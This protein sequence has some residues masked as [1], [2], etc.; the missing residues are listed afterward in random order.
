MYPDDLCALLGSFQV[1]DILI[2]IPVF[3]VCWQVGAATFGGIIYR[4][5]RGFE[6]KN[7]GMYIS[8]VLVM[9]AGI[10][11]ATR[12]M[13]IV[14]AAAA[15]GVASTGNRVKGAGGELEMCLTTAEDDS[16]DDVIL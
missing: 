6:S 1:N 3:Y 11:L 13:A 15:A 4:E 7:W 16:E 10:F 2:H 5:Y 8:G 12:R 14:A 9:F